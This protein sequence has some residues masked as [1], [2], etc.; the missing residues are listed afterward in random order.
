[1]ERRELLTVIAGVAALG[2]ACTD[3][4]AADGGGEV[5]V[6]RTNTTRESEASP[7]SDAGTVRVDVVL[8]DE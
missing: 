2:T 7:A 1:M 4:T 3:R 8:V 5:G 6:R